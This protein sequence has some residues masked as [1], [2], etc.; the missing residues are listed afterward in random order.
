MKLSI[1]GTT[2]EIQASIELNVNDSQTKRVF[3]QPDDNPS[4]DKRRQTTALMLEKMRQK[5]NNSCSS[6]A[7]GIGEIDVIGLRPYLQ[8]IKVVDG[9]AY[10]VGPP[11]G[12]GE[13][14]GSYEINMMDCGGGLVILPKNMGPFSKHWEFGSTS[15][16]EK[17]NQV[18]FKYEE[19]LKGEK[20][21]GLIKHVFKK[22]LV[23]NCGEASLSP[24]GEKSSGWNNEVVKLNDKM[25]LTEETTKQSG[26]GGSISRENSNSV[27]EGLTL[28]HMVKKM[29]KSKSKSSFRINGGLIGRGLLMR[30]EKNVKLSKAKCGKTKMVNKMDLVQIE[31]KLQRTN[32]RIVDALRVKEM[33]KGVWVDSNRASGGLV[34]L[35]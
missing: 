22:N 5:D 29:K 32:N 33:Y 17:P 13:L 30:S 3:P 2:Y 34:S 6:L 15:K 24:E 20:L 35:W 27:D 16:M 31:S 10:H 18:K 23:V 11:I 7:S 9:W 28:A 14:E 12:C 21:C 19:N 25:N 8:K 26:D 1:R 4:E